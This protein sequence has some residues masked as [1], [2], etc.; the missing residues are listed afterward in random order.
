MFTCLLF[1]RFQ[2]W[3]VLVSVGKKS[4]SVSIAVYIYMIW[5]S[6]IFIIDLTPI[7]KS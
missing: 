4:V 2:R 7:H 1:R 5:T 6:Y 3:E